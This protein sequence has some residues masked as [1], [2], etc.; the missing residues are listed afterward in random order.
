MSRS[1]D[2]RVQ[3]TPA[4][5]VIG[6]P[7]AAGLLRVIDWFVPPSLRREGGDAVALA[8]TI[9]AVCLS[10]IAWGGAL[11]AR[12]LQLGEF[13]P[14]ACAVIVT[15]GLVATPFVMRWT[16][17]L[18][19]A[20][21][22]VLCSV[23][24]G[25]A[26]SALSFGGWRSPVFVV[27][28]ALPAAA[29]A[30]RGQR[31]AIALQAATMAVGIGT[32][33]ADGLGW[34]DFGAPRPQTHFFLSALVWFVLAWLWFVVLSAFQR[35]NRLAL[36]KLERSNADL[37]AARDAADAASRAKSA[38]LANMSHEIRTPLNGVLGLAELLQ[39]TALDERQRHLS[40]SIRLSARSLLDVINQVLDYSKVASAEI[41]LES[42]PF[43]L[44]QPVREVLRCLAV[45]AEQKGLELISFFDPRLPA[46]VVGDEFRARQVLMNLVG[47][48]IKFTERGE[49]TVR[50]RRGGE[51]SPAGSAVCIEV[52]DTG[53]GCDEATRARIF[54]PFV[55]A[56]ESTTRRFG[57]T[58][59]GLAISA[60]LAARMGGSIE[61]ESAPGRGSLFRFRVVFERAES[62]AGA[63]RARSLGE[64][65]PRVLVAEP[66]PA[67]RRALGDYLEALGLPFATVASLDE[68]PR[69]SDGRT[70]PPDVVIA[71]ARLGADRVAAARSALAAEQRLVVLHGTADSSRDE[72]L[73]ADCARLERPVLPDPLVAC[74]GDGRAAAGGRGVPAQAPPATA[75]FSGRVLVAE[76]NPVN[77]LV[78]RGML[79]SLGCEVVVVRDGSEAL[80]ASRKERFDLV[81]MD[82]QMPVMDGVAATRALRE[83]EG[84]RERTPILALTADLT[85]STRGEANRAGLDGFVAKPFSRAELASALSGFLEPAREA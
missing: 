18:E 55:Q 57:G 50:V 25:V 44:E 43:E 26:G 12:D 8:R 29:I 23:Y 67:Q 10:A 30:M 33:T 21:P 6:A 51:A 69:W 68:R 72:A 34:I 5:P 37:S 35:V 56:D 27:L 85:E 7:R 80:E 11:V 81:L 32:F 53:I 4:D 66:H 31:L 49:V 79:E 62:D 83:R 42:K 16:D 1:V 15:V 71:D 76:D 73:P 61:V 45:T 59:L 74:L 41:E 48:A 64:A 39:E 54:S 78:A 82:L 14:L 22:L 75:R 84:A 60:Q 20:R 40:E 65:R 17:R 77:Q 70:V 19:V 9:T 36:E 47:N 13:L 2:P 28:A 3:P 63:P 46:V 58:G 24:A 38:F 52:E